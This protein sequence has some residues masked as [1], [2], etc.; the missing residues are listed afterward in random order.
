MIRAALAAG[1]LLAAAGCGGGPA[2]AGS[3][4]TPSGGR[5]ASLTA[6][7]VGTASAV[8]HTVHGSRSTVQGDV[9][10][11]EL[12]RY[13]DLA[14]EAVPRVTAV[15]G[16]HW[17]RHL[18]VEVFGSRAEMER[19]LHVAAGTYRDL[20]AVTVGEAGA[21]PGIPAG[22]IVVNPE[23]MQGLSRTGRLVVLTHEATH[24][25][26]RDATSA[27][28][29]TWLSEGYAD[30][31]AYRGSGLTT[32]QITAE[33][34]EE[35]RTEPRSRRPAALPADGDFAPAA[36]GAPTRLA[37]AYELAW[38][39]CRLIARQHGAAALTAFYRRIGAEHMSPDR[40]M[41]AGSGI[42]LAQ[43]TREWVD[44]LADLPP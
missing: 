14:D 9:P 33:L 28:T 38:T 10:A 16:T 40:A 37:A 34:R 4:P 27:D 31:I 25:A 26:T 44:S 42:S 2:P 19:R 8:R 39:A 11:A 43:F 18:T 30:F 29:P 23:A 24:V 21:V 12:R 20:A 5:S 36:A 7:S 1:A 35:L 41:R 17:D 3:S 13:A 6:S 15:W 32:A 22:R